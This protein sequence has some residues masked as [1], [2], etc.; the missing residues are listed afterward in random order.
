MNKIAVE[1]NIRNENNSFANGT[2]DREAYPKRWVA[3]LVQMNCEKKVASKLDKLG[4]T[5][6]I[7]IQKEEHQ[8]SDRKK[9]IDRVVIPMVVFVHLAQGEE[10]EF[11][12][13]PFILKFITYPGSE[14]LATS[15]P[16]EQISSLKTL[17]EKAPNQVCFESRIIHKGDKVKV[18]KGTLKDL[19]GYVIQENANSILVLEIGLLGCVKLKID[20]SF[21]SLVD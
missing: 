17:L 1:G 4:I 20:K 13:L 2:N 7:P 8:W 5:N 16:D 3:T 18:T 21:L 11:R 10:D 14:E 19:E 12:K 9:T 6:Y 15:I